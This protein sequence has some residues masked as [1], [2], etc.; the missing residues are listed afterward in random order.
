M[1]AGGEGHVPATFPRETDPVPILQ[2]AVR[3]Q[4]PVWAGA[5]KRDGDSILGSS[6]P[7]RVAIPTELSR[8]TVEATLVLNMTLYV[9][10]GGA[11]I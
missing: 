4:L 8:P 6:S 10:T 7:Y 5:E 11:E 3:A 9:T 1:C 2:E